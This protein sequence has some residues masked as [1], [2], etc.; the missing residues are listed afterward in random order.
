MDNPTIQTMLSHRSVRKYTSQKPTE[1]VLE[2]IVRAGQQAPFASQL[3]S[4]LLTRK[5]APFGAALWFTVCVDLYKLERF[6]KIR[7]WEIVSNDLSMLLFGFQD[8]A[9]MAEN[10]VVAGESLGLG[11]C[12]LG[13]TPYRA[14]KIQKQYKLPKRV[15]PLVELVMGYPAE[16]FPPRPRYPLEFTLFED[17]YPEMTDEMVEQ[18]MKVMDDG[19][20]SQGYYV[21]QKA[22]IRLEHGRKETFTYDN[23]SWTE[24]ISRKW[25]QW[26]DDPRELLE[27]FEKCGFEIGKKK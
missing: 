15:F 8:A 17:R 9:L 19:Y 27:Q 25:G 7:G 1:E 23:Y 11:S 20:L 26:L 6:M 18:A 5:K 4:L 16:E 10:L 21:K 22:K 13:N 24:H 2:T 3:Y 12:F 14:D